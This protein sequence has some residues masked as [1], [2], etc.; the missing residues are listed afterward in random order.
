MQVHLSSPTTKRSI[1]IAQHAGLCFG[2]KRAL[3][4]ALH[5]AKHLPHPVYTLGPIIHNPQ[6]VEYLKTKGVV[7][8]DDLSHITE[9]TVIIRSHGIPK[10]TLAY[11][12]QKKLTVV[13]A[14][15]PF[16]KKAQQIVEKLYGDMIP[17][18][19]IGEKNHPEVVA[20]RSYSS[21]T[22]IIINDV[23]ELRSMIAQ[24]PKAISIVCQ[25]TQPQE[26]LDEIITYLSANGITP[27]VYNTICDATLKRQHE[28][29]E[30]A[31]NVEAVLVIGGHN[32]ANTRR[33]FEICK[34]VQLC[35]ISCETADDCDCTLLSGKNRIAI[36]T[37]ASTPS[38]IIRK[39]IHTVRRNP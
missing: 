4:M 17:T 1:I 18:L 8:L 28:A 32:S 24:L 31:K 14:T 5:A 15:C 9:G 29:R 10:E 30:L 22:T 20:M 2:V 23:H 39:V 19:I 6:A 13:D 38:W 37:G 34:A 16:V 12:E 11:L 27:T 21:D 3:K 36:I 35:T 25:T 26:K 7:P 33:L